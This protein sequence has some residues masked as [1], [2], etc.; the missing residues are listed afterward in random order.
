MAVHANSQIPTW[1]N[2]WDSDFY[3]AL[4]GQENEAYLQ[5]GNYSYWYAYFTSLVSALTAWKTYDRKSDLTDFINPVYGYAV[6]NTQFG[7]DGSLLSQ[8]SAPLLFNMDGFVEDCKSRGP[9]YYNDL[10]PVLFTSAKIEADIA[11]VTG[12]PE[13]ERLA[14]RTLR[15]EAQGFISGFVVKQLFEDL[16]P[17]TTIITKS[18]MANLFFNTYGFKKVYQI[19]NVGDLALPSS[20]I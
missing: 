5:A 18:G 16:P 20:V 19:L 12:A 13:I 7:N 11:T 6:L 4:T 14:L 2:D 3:I 8:I 10:D 15:S 17:P 1:V 9:T